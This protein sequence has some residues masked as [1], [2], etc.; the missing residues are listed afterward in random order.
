[1][2]TIFDQK[3]FPFK[4]KMYLCTPKGVNDKHGKQN[5]YRKQHQKHGKSRRKEL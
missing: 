3:A 5:G 1:M 4:K 2:N